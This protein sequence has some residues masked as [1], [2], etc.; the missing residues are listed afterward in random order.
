M[1]PFFTGNF[2]LKWT[3]PSFTLTRNIQINPVST[4]S[5]EKLQPNYRVPWK[6]QRHRQNWDGNKQKKLQ[7]KMLK[8][9]M[10]KWKWIVQKQRNKYSNPRNRILCQK[11]YCEI[12]P[13]SSSTKKNHFTF[14]TSQ[15]LPADQ[16]HWH[17]TAQ[18]LRLQ[19]AQP[20]I[21]EKF[22]L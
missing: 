13:R 17:L 7:E 20:I 22:L 18:S 9:E 15:L 6:N 5:H 19:H 8:K 2:D 21:Q 11:L 3:N 12:A 4:E 14:S 1:I 10:H 16:S